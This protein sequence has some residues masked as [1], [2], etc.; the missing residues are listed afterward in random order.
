SLAEQVVVLLAATQGLFD[1]LPL[2][3]VSSAQQSLVSLVATSASDV[4][5]RITSTGQLSEGDKQALLA[6]AKEALTNTTNG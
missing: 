6:V 5:E 1:A 3:E 4:M 2:D